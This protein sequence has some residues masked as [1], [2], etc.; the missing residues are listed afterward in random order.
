MA[1]GMVHMGALSPSQTL[2]IKMWVF[3]KP[4]AAEAK[5]DKNGLVELTVI[6]GKHD[7][8]K[9]VLLWVYRGHL[10]V[11]NGMV[12]MG[13]LSP[14][15]TL[16]IK[17]WVFRKPKAA[18]AKHDKNGLVELTV[19]HGKHD[20]EKM[21]LMFYFLFIHSIRSTLIKSKESASQWGSHHLIDNGVITLLYRFCQ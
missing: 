20:N 17:M 8:E 9:M 15:Q 14:S 12:H 16:E 1:N 19:I 3:R 11:A 5:H 18:E 10:P 21:V 13:V 6:H 4:K 2:E 7:N